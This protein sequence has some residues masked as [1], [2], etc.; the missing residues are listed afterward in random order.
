MH[1]IVSLY[2]FGDIVSFAVLFGVVLPRNF[3]LLSTSSFHSVPSQPYVSVGA[4]GRP[5]RRRF[6]DF[7]VSPAHNLNAGPH[8]M[9]TLNRP[10]AVPELVDAIGMV[11]TVVHRCLLVSTKSCFE[12]CTDFC[13]EFIQRL[14]VSVPPEGLLKLRESH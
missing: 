7:S 10:F 4:M 5:G 1:D 9:S 12:L 2:P 6:S 13:S 8:D 3:P 14:F 11:N